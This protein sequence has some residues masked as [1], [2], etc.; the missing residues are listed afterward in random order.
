MSISTVFLI[1]CN[2]EHDEYAY[3][4]F[5]P[6]YNPAFETCTEISFLSANEFIQDVIETLTDR[7]VLQLIDTID[8]NHWL[9]IRF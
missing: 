8:F 2:T 9:T 7:H 1:C 5:T 6:E 3:I 4:K